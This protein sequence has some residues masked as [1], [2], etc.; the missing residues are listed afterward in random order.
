M[1]MESMDFENQLPVGST[2]ILSASTIKA[3]QEFYK[4]AV[5]VIS[6][7][8]IENVIW[9]CYQKL[10]KDVTSKLNDYG[11][12]TES[13]SKI[14]Y[15]DMLSNIFG[16]K[17]NYEN[18]LYCSSPTEYK[19]ILRSMEVQLAKGRSNLIIFD[20]LNAL[21]SYDAIEQMIRFIRNLNNVISTNCA[22][23]IYLYISAISCSEKDVSLHAA[24]DNIYYLQGNTA[25]PWAAI[26]WEN[27]KN[28][29]WNDVLTS[30]API[31][32]VLLVVMMVSNITLLI[33]FLSLITISI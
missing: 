29:T 30:N 31:I 1:M 32:F 26:S 28:T 23:I 14:Q 33:V 16:L 12:N 2:L 27:F 9:I 20:N 17:Q 13:I 8:E 11:V 24:M 22:S 21:M 7:P 19:C 15:I 6:N 3:E 4:I 5:K 18:T 10:P 25:K